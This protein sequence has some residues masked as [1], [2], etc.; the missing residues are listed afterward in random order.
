ADR[1]ALSLVDSTVATQ[2]QGNQQQIGYNLELVKLAMSQLEADTLSAVE[3]QNLLNEVT[4]Y[5][6]AIQ[7]LVDY[8]TNIMDLAR[9]SKV[10]SAESVKAANTSV[11]TAELMDLNTK[12]VNEIYLSTIGSEVD[13]FTTAQVN[14]LYSIAD[15]CPM[16]GGEAVFRARALYALV[17]NEQDFDDA[18]LCLQQGIIVKSVQQQAP[19]VEQ[20]VVVPNPAMDAA[21]LVLH[22]KLDGPAV[23][24]VF[25]TLGSEV[26]RVELSAETLRLSFS[27]ERLAP[28]L[29]HYQVRG[30][31]ELIGE[32]K[33][34][35]IR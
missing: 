29:Y 14:A 10:L 19:R 12:Q 26:M 22:E 27:T 17:N 21:T 11:A 31:A 20:A 34:S 16:V 5:Q 3:R 28:A 23:F 9:T 7:A 4:G 2:L 24:V 15:Q 1:G 32:G 18:L 25:N 13:T 6:A 30:P 35:I 8:N 33:L